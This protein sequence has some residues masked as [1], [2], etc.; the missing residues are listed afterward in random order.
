MFQIIKKTVGR[1]LGSHSNTSGKDTRPQRTRETNVIPAKAVFNTFIAGL[2]KADSIMI[3]TSH[4]DAKPQRTRETNVIPAKA[5]IQGNAL[6]NPGHDL[7]SEK[8]GSCPRIQYIHC[9]EALADEAISQTSDR[10]IRSRK[11]QLAKA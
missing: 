3:N 2:D 5:G 10:N 11:K 4:K 8:W 7:I 6:K 1:S 9:E